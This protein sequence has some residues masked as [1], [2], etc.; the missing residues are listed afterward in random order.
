MHLRA[1]DVSPCPGTLQLPVTAQYAERC[2]GNAVRHN[3]PPKVADSRTAAPDIRL[4]TG[5]LEIFINLK[6]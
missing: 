5:E 1:C 4:K 6:I 2:G 3:M